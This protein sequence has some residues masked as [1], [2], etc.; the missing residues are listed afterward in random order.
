M[1]YTE[2]EEEVCCSD[3]VSYLHLC[4]QLQTLI[5]GGKG[6]II[7]IL[8]LVFFGVMLCVWLVKLLK[9]DIWAF[10]NTCSLNL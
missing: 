1:N 10:W 9:H 4:F 8:Q 6:E 5:D 3:N 2:E 7:I